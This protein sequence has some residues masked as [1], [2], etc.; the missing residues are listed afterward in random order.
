MRSS[1]Q[2][3]LPLNEYIAD[4]EPHV[5]GDRIYLYGSHD[6][7][8]G[9]TYCER[10]YEFYSASVYDITKWDS[11][12]TSYR[13]CQDEQFDKEKPYLFAPDCVQGKDGRYYLYYAM[14]GQNGKGGYQGPIKVAVSNEPDGPFEFY[15]TVCDKQGEPWKEYVPFDPAVINDQGVIRLYYGAGYGFSNYQKGFL[16]KTMAK[17]QSAVYEKTVEEIQS[18]AD[19]I[20]GAVTVELGADMLTV[21][22]K[23]K[24]ITPNVTRGTMW[25]KHPFFEASSIRKIKDT[26][27][28]IYSSQAGH[29]LCYAT[30]QYPDREFVFRGVLISNGDIG[31][32]GRKEKNR[33]AATG[34][35]HGSIECINGN[36]YLFYHRQTNGTNFSRQACAEPIEIKEDGSIPQVSVT[37][38]GL[39]GG[40]VR[41]SEWYPA[42]IACILSNGHM[43]EIGNP[44]AGRKVPKITEKNNQVYIENIWKGTAIGIRYFEFSGKEYVL[45]MDYGNTGQWKIYVD[46][47]KKN[48]IGVVSKTMKT[49]LLKPPKGK[50]PLIF[51]YVGSGKAEFYEFYLAENKEADDCEEE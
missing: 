49:T 17:V 34:N 11:R 50:H 8:D 43:K 15:G 29:E 27:Y 20:N 38:F 45:K 22:S 25:E 41:P 16:K 9:K 19:G 4:G 31:F 3:F 23:A 51:E 21:V 13:A 32:H 40:S 36:W 1:F 18:Y 47:E 30:S 14:A 33:I 5:F 7:A 39:Y 48:C 26:Y 10:D 42:A 35:N 37:S 46:E 24:R 12:G 6:A 28:F 2:L 44:F